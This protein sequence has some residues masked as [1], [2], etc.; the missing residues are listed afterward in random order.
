[1]L[2]NISLSKRNATINISVKVKF[3]FDLFNLLEPAFEST[4]FQL[5]SHLSSA[6]GV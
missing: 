2:N 6:Y 1:M 4:L 5:V 3:L